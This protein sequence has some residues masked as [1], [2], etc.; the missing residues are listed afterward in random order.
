[1]RNYEHPIGGAFYTTRWEKKRK[2]RREEQQT[3]H[4]V[5]SGPT[6]VFV[7]LTK[8]RKKTHYIHTNISYDE[9]YLSFLFILSAD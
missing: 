1:M 8:K 7:P 5:C 6:S 4:C 2:E 3:R 9:K